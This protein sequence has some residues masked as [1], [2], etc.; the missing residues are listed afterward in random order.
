M[1]AVY[2]CEIKSGLALPDFGHE[3]LGHIQEKKHPEVL[4]SSV[5]AWKLLEAA[6]RLNGLK[7]CPVVHFESKGKPR[8]A[9]SALH[10]SLA[11]SKNLAAAMLSD[12]P[13]GI[14]IELARPETAHKL[15]D[16]CLSERE[17]QIERPDFFTFWTR[18]ECLAKYTGTG[19]GAHPARIDTLDPGL[20]GLCFHTETIFD[21]VGNEYRLSA[22]SEREQPGHAIKI[23][24]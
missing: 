3:F 23:I 18:K 4:A 13:C 20:S 17:K 22:V 2:F 14:D 21:E 5:S 11:H 19:I 9:D 6:L 15:F 16:R 24:L 8:F 7:A 10:F 1:N 12:A